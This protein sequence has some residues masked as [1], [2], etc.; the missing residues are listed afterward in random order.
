MLPSLTLS[1]RQLP[2]ASNM[3]PHPPPT[4]I[5]AEVYSRIPGALRRPKRIEWAEFNKTGRAFDCFLEGPSFDRMSRPTHFI[6]PVDA[7]FVSTIAFDGRRRFIT[8]GKSSSIP[9]AELPLAGN[10]MYDFV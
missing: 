9:T 2:E 3:S 6:D 8:E 4:T 1:F 10:T 7:P 5:K